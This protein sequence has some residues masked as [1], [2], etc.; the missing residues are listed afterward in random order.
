MVK[1]KKD[2]W[3]ILSISGAAG[4]IFYFLHVILGGIL[5]EGYSHIVQTISELTASNAPNGDL[6]RILTS[7]YGVL[8]IIFSIA[9]YCIFKRKNLKKTAIIGSALLIIME[10]TSLFGYSLFPL[11]TTGVMMNFRNIMHIVVTA[12]V[13]LSSIGSIFF[14]GIGLYKSAGYKGIGAFV[15]IC[16]VIFTVSGMI[17]PV[18]MAKGIPIAGLIERINIFTLQICLFVLSVYIF[19]DLK[20]NAE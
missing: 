11:D 19:R 12:V 18:I 10:T 20:R 7:V 4:I 6:L 14:I 15:L 5:W 13:V 17:S 9:L 3:Q 16:A 2:I 8:M 1:G